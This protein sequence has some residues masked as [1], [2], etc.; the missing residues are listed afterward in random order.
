MYL[1]REGQGHITDLERSRSEQEY[2]FLLEGE[3][4]PDYRFMLISKSLCKTHT[5]VLNSPPVYL[6]SGS[7]LTTQLVSSYRHSSQ[8]NL[9]LN[10]NMNKASLEGQSHAT[11]QLDDKS[12]GQ[13][14]YMNVK[15]N[16]QD[17]QYR[18]GWPDF[19]CLCLDKN[20]TADILNT[21]KWNWVYQNTMNDPFEPKHEFQGPYR[22]GKRKV[23][24]RSN[25]DCEK[26]EKSF[27]SP[28][29]WMETPRNSEISGESYNTSDSCL[30][31]PPKLMSDHVVDKKR[32]KQ[33]L[34][35]IKNELNKDIEITSQDE[36]CMEHSGKHQGTSISMQKL[37]GRRGPDIN[38]FDRR[39]DTSQDTPGSGNEV[40]YCTVPSLGYLLKRQERHLY[41]KYSSWNIPID[42]Q[43]NCSIDSFR[44]R[45][46]VKR[47]VKPDYDGPGWHTPVG[48]CGQT[49]AK[50]RSEPQ[51]L[52]LQRCQVDF[53]PQHQSSCRQQQPMPAKHMLSS[54]T[55]KRRCYV[56][57]ARNHYTQE[58]PVAYLY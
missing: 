17:V 9:L 21:Q 8:S 19:S 40:L 11:S 45:P 25:I 57:H 36:C 30:S 15:Q 27:L 58:C 56:C 37:E 32:V 14:R 29:P 16:S 18:R 6:T 28:S 26:R 44:E 46:S 3:G 13:G 55:R 48:Q 1:T 47:N 51:N 39:A 7:K 12:Q 2:N 43:K 41:D 34:L 4:Q 5:S 53:D 33:I 35:P 10:I 20:L 42:N 38:T 23:L 49:N 50:T 22:R 54:D 24:Q 52:I 31:D